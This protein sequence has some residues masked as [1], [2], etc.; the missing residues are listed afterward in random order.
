MYGVNASVPKTLMQHLVHYVADNSDENTAK[1]LYS[2][3]DTPISPELLP[4]DKNG[5]M[6]QKTE[7][8]LGPYEVHDY[9]LYHFIRNGTKPEKLWLSAKQAFKGIYTEEELRRWLEIFLRRFFVSQFKRSCSPD[10]PKIGSVSLSPRGAWAMPSD[11]CF[12]E[13]MKF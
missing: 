3:L 13:W 9:Y 2:V 6:E 5:K 4:P 11:A 8:T 1:I 12:N 7:N 10:G